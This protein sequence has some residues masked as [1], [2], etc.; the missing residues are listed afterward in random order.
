[1][2]LT[3]TFDPDLTYPTLHSVQEAA[4]FLGLS[5][6]CIYKLV[7]SHELPAVRI[8]ASIRISSDQLHDVMTRGTRPIK[9]RAHK[10][11][12]KAAAADAE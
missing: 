8:G 3:T 2:Q 9:A 7:Q 1:M 4:D 6:Y 11:R 12:K 10:D 5:P